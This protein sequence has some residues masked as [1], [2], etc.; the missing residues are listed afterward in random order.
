MN[1]LTEG[2]LPPRQ[3]LRAMRQAVAYL[4]G[5]VSGLGF[6]SFMWSQSRLVSEVGEFTPLYQ[7]ISS[8][9]IEGGNL[10]EWIE[11]RVEKG[12]LN[13]VELFVFTG[14]LIFESVLYKRT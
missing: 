7:G 11:R 10:K 2:E 8:N 12:G 13:N 9:S 3:R 4:I 1:F 14:N 5:D 6:G